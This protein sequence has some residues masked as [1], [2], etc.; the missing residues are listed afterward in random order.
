M[1]RQ[2]V[3]GPKTSKSMAV[4]SKKAVIR[5][6]PD[7]SGAVLQKRGGSK[8]RKPLRFREDAEAVALGVAWNES[9]GKGRKQPAYSKASMPATSLLH[10]PS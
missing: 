10:L 9:D 6:H 3:R 8:I 4:K 7:E 1:R 2:A 5:T